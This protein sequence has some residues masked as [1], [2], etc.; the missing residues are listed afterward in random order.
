MI[1]PRGTHNLI[2]RIFWSL[3]ISS[4]GR[5]GK[6]W[7][8]M[9]KQPSGSTSS[10]EILAQLEFA[11]ADKLGWQ[12]IKK[13][14]RPTRNV[15]WLSL[16]VDLLGPFI[17]NVSSNLLYPLPRSSVYFATLQTF[18][19]RIYA[20]ARATVALATNSFIVVPRSLF[21][22]S[23]MFARGADPVDARVSKRLP[24]PLRNYTQEF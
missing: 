23:L 19:F 9:V 24:I 15:G 12:K 5:F 7:N 8:E 14:Q 13:F 11:V 3:L 16:N 4:R 1:T 22:D 17:T 21:V 2:F 18:P 10:L 20:N 6:P